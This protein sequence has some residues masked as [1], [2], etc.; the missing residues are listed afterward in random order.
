M[1]GYEYETPGEG[2]EEWAGSLNETFSAV[3]A[4]VRALAARVAALEDAAREDPTTEGVGI[5]PRTDYSR[6]EQRYVAPDGGDGAA[7]TRED[8]WSVAAAEGASPGTVVNFL[9]G[10]YDGRIA[11]P[12][13][14]EDA[15]VVFRSA[16]RHAARVTDDYRCFR[17]REESHVTIQGFRVDG[18]DWFDLK[19]AE[20]VTIRDN[21]CTGTRDGHSPFGIEGSDGVRILNNVLRAGG[22]HNMFTAMPGDQD[23]FEGLLVAGNSF[24]R[25]G[26]QPAGLFFEFADTVWRGNVF[27]NMVGRNF[28]LNGGRR[29]VFEHNLVA[30][31]FDGPESAGPTGKF[32]VQ[33]GVFRFNRVLLNRGTPVVAS[34]Y[35]P[36]NSPVGPLRVYN[37]VFAANDGGGFN[38][39]DR[40]TDVEYLADT[41]LKNNVFDAASSAAPQVSWGMNNDRTEMTFRDNLFSGSKPVQLDDERLSLS[42]AESRLG[43]AASGNVAGDPGFEDVDAADLSPAG[44]DTARAGGPLTRTTSAGSGRRVPVADARYVHDGLGIDGLS[45]DPVRVGEQTATVTGVDWG[46]GV[47]EV[48]RSLSWDEGA[49]VGLPWGSETPR[50]GVYQGGDGFAQVEVEAP[51]NARTG[52]RV[53]FSAV[54]HGDVEVEEVAWQFGDGAGAVGRRVAHSYETPYDY[55]VRVR[56]TDAA[57]RVHWGTHYLYVAGDGVDPSTEAYAR[58]EVEKFDED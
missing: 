1:A 28:G 26:H 29:A 56:V 20:D 6:F 4:D 54:V 34:P 7:G 45:G 58:S 40:I 36:W 21:F 13:G 24:S 14:D 41:V 43:D 19:A 27:H 49:P 9:P 47:V 5:T 53:T 18:Y 8:P 15:P 38:F 12:G 39:F 2:T 42:A 11:V 55:G 30:S 10:E 25:A 37:N 32:T 33:D 50:A 46:D 17:V 44:G 52:E 48:D 35:Q 51:L 22:N 31:A 57:G 16:E 23:S 3:D